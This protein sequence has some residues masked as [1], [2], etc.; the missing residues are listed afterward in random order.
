[1]VSCK[2]FVVPYTN[3]HVDSSSKAL[4]LSLFLLTPAKVYC[5]LLVLLYMQSVHYQ[6][7]RLHIA[8]HQLESTIA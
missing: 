6:S 7:S 3:V 2:I 1:V 8:L 5:F 4:L